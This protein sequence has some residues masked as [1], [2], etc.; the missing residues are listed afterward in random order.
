MVCFF[1]KFYFQY[2]TWKG[3]VEGSDGGDEGGHNQGEDQRLQHPEEDLAHVGD[4]HH[5]PLRPVLLAAAEDQ[6]EDDAADD[7]RHGPDGEAV[8]AQTS[9]HLVQLAAHLGSKYP[10]I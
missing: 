8:G 9:P 6:P 5:L 4:V 2:P 7:A 10:D 3:Q 1:Y